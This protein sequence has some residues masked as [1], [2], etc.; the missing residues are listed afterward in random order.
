MDSILVDKV[1]NYL[2]ML[3]YF[4]IVDCQSSFILSPVLVSLSASV[5]VND[6]VRRDWSIKSGAFRNFENFQ[7][8][9]VPVFLFRKLLKVDVPKLYFHIS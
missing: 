6:P 8:S 9:P 3:I 7:Q 4:V 5:K 2:K 1:D